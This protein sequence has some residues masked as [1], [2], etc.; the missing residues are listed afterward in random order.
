MICNSTAGVGAPVFVKE[1]PTCSYIFE[2][3]TAYAC[4]LGGG[5]LPMPIENTL[6]FPSVNFTTAIANV[7]FDNAAV[8]VGI[9]TRDLDSVMSAGLPVACDVPQ[10]GYYACV[11]SNVVRDISVMVYDVALLRITVHDIKTLGYSV[12]DI[13]ADGYMLG[14]RVPANGNQILTHTANK[15]FGDLVVMSAPSSSE[16]ALVDGFEPFFS[17]SKS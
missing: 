17:V 11:W 16:V 8:T 5:K 13:A 3:A 9:V 14:S 2:W 1:S 6:Y 7:A 10:D 4:P 12:A 15:G